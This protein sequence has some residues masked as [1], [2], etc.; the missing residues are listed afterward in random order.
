[1][2]ILRIT[3]TVVLLYTVGTSG[4]SETRP[5][6]AGHWVLNKAKSKEYSPSMFKRRS[7]EVSQKDPGLDI[8]IRDEEPDGREFRAYLN[9]KTNGE[10]AV[11]ILGSP[12]RAVVRWEDSKLVIRWNLDGTAVNSSGS[13]GRQGAT[14]PFTWTWTLTASGK[15]L[16]NQ[17]HVY[18]ETGDIIERLVYDKVP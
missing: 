15:T 6:F 1:M 2:T 8:D 14:P 4:H 13:S 11:A 7:M 9:L 17:I 12:Q 16:I 5:D 18:S 3:A 10:T